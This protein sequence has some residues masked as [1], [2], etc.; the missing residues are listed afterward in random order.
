[1]VKNQT[2]FKVYLNEI[3]H[4]PSVFVSDEFRN[5]VLESDLKGFEFITVWDSEAN[6]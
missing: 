3:V 5:T 6:M 2:I 4:T 1:M